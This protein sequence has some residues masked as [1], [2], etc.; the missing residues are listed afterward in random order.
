MNRVLKTISYPSGQ[1]LEIVHGDLTQEPV[2]AI[3]NAANKHLAHGGG[4]AGIIARKGGRVI[5]DESSAWVLKN[6]PVPYNQPAYTHAGNLPFRYII[7]AVGPIW[8]QGDEDGRLAS[9][10][11]GS[12]VRADELGIASISFPAISTGIFG[13]PRDRAARVIFQAIRDYFAATPAS[14]IKIVRLALYDEETLDI[15]LHEL[16]TA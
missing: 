9:A 10:V 15:F 6:G 16:E 3:V 7:H 14:G 12:L 5:D 4:V 8:G 2:E 11:R 13:F 1:R